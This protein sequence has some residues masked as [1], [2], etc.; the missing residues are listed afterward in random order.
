M[1]FVEQAVARVGRVGDGTQFL[2]QAF[3]LVR[4]QR[5]DAGHVPK[6]VEVGHLVIGEPVRRPLGRI[7]RNGK[8]VADES[9][10]G[11]KVF[12]GKALHGKRV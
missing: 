6:R 7:R 10:A 8:Q 12:G 9:L 11:R 1:K 2:F 4:L 5:L 3:H